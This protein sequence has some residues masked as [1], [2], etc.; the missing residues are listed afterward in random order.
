MANSEK[1]LPYIDLPLQHANDT[2]LS[3]MNRRGSRADI[4]A[5]LAKIRKTLPHACVRT[6]F[7]C[8]FPGE[9]PEQFEQLCDF[10]AQQRF[11]RMGCFA[12]SAEEGTPAADFPNQ[13]DE[14][15]KQRRTELLMTLQNTIST[16]LNQEMVGKTLPVLVEEY[17]EEL[18]RYAGRSYRDA[19]EVDGRVYFTSEQTHEEGCFVD[20]TVTAADDYDLY[21]KA[22]E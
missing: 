9:T 14:A 18:G 17:D 7:I 10:V 21:G 22:A 12:Y 15:E 5:V 8:G 11:E 2:I 1:I 13:V 6:T 3:A 20:V 4:E 19:P 16:Q